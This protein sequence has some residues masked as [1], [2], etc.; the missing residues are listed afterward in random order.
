VEGAFLVSATLKNGEISGLT[1]ISEQGR[2]L[3]L[4]N[5]WEGRKVKVTE[6]DKEKIYE[7]EHIEIST[8]A[9]VTY[10][11]TPV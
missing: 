9:G 7:G 11:F 8:K 10:R 2:P 3:N 5:P 1:I 4:L 6:K